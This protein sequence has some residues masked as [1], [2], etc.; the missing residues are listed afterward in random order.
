MCKNIFCQDGIKSGDEI[1]KID[2]LE[3]EELLSVACVIEKLSENFSNENK[4]EETGGSVRDIT[5]QAIRQT[6]E[7]NQDL[8]RQNILLEQKLE[9]KERQIEELENKKIDL[10]KVNN[11]EL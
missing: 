9:E 1:E 7:E 10:A 6:I 3:S 11:D 2:S 4:E 5:S 8:K